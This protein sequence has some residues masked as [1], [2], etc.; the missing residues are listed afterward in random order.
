MV[1][2]WDVHLAGFYSQFIVCMLRTWKMELLVTSGAVMGWLQMVWR[3]WR[4][5]HVEKH[6][7][8]VKVEK[9][10]IVLSG[11]EVHEVDVD[12][13]SEQ[14]RLLVLRHRVIFAFSYRCICSP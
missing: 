13:I 6:A 11:F 2:N 4:F 14:N 8:S 7:S 3:C 9:Y 10:F 12:Q 5:L 1:L